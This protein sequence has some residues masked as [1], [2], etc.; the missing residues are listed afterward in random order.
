MSRAT[1]QGNSIIAKHLLLYKIFSRTSKPIVRKLCTLKMW[2]EEIQCYLTEDQILFQVF[3]AESATKKMTRWVI[4]PMGL[5]FEFSVENI[6]SL[7]ILTFQGPFV[8]MYVKQILGSR[9]KPPAL[10]LVRNKKR[11]KNAYCF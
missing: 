8:E 10:L 3:F 1:F 2:I 11:K 5:L 4:C 9:S 6:S 7:Q